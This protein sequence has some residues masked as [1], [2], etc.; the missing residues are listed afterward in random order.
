[1]E[2]GKEMFEHMEAASGETGITECP[3]CAMQMGHG[4]GYEIKHPLEVLEDVV[5]AG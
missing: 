5:V 3:T 2:I 1:M 4:T